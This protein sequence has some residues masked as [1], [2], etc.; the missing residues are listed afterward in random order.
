MQV[1][2]ALQGGGGDR[3]VTEKAVALF[4]AVADL[5]AAPVTRDALLGP[6]LTADLA[7]LVALAMPCQA[8]C[9]SG[10]KAGPPSR[11][12]V[13]AAMQRMPA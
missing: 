12:P 7:R 10:F 8:A 11:A 9:L 13:T 3:A 5:L 6:A 4:A 2:A 1:S